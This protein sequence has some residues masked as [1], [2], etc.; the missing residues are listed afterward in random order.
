MSIGEIIKTTIEPIKAYSIQHLLLCLGLIAV[1]A[2]LVFFMKKA[3]K[4]TVITTIGIVLAV[5][6]VTKQVFMQQIYTSYSWSDV[7]FQ[8]CSIPMYL[9][10]AYPFAKKFRIVIENFL[11]SFGLL[12]AIVAFAMPYDVFAKYIVLSIQS[13]VWHEI[14]LVVGLYCIAAAPKDKKLKANDI[15]NNALLYLALALVAI[16]INA[17]LANVSSGTANMFFLGPSKPYTV[18]LDDIYESSGWIVES[19]AM[20]GCSEACGAVVFII[21]EVMSKLCYRLQNVKYS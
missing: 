20:I 1:A 3:K 10:L 12:G 9:C 11:R 15:G 17:A 4:T 14:L 6:E 16:V 13:I 7:P 8:L 21:G 2:V 19:I 18:I 5:N